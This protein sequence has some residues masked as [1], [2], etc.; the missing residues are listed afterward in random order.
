MKFDIDIQPEF[1]RHI[2]FNGGTAMLPGLSTRLYEDIRDLWVE[3]VAKGDRY[4]L[5]RFKLQIEDPPEL[6]YLAYIGGS[7][8]ADIMKQYPD[9]WLSK[10]DYNEKGA[11]RATQQH[12]TRRKKNNVDSVK[13]N[14]NVNKNKA[15]NEVFNI[16]QQQNVLNRPREN[17]ILPSTGYQ[18]RKSETSTQHHLNNNNNNNNNKKRVNTVKLNKSNNGGSGPI[19]PI[20]NAY[21]KRFGTAPLSASQLQNFS[22]TTNEWETLNFKQSRDIFNN[23]GIGDN[24]QKKSVIDVQQSTTKQ[25][26]YKSP[27][28]TNK[29][30]AMPATGNQSKVISDRINKWNH[31][32]TRQKNKA[33]H[34]TVY[35][36][37][38]CCLCCYI[39]FCG[40]A[41]CI[42][43]RKHQ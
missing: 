39:C 22:K 21:I 31:N 32:E 26:S 10:L 11:T 42:I 37:I 6:K 19:N 9:V 33:I 40:N 13:A 23:G 5:N 35:F 20:W 41:I 15:D 34:V 12:H 43:Y 18:Q 38:C 36:C 14:D 16:K 29:T 27:M 1:F 4:R 28:E 8:W 17:K 7:V 25:I 30:L 2:V 3:R 24:Y